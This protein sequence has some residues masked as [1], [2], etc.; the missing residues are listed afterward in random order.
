[1]SFSSTWRSEQRSHDTCM[2]PPCKL[3]RLLSGFYPFSRFDE[4]ME[5]KA[6][7]RIWDTGFIMFHLVSVCDGWAWMCWAV[8]AECAPCR[9]EA[10]GGHLPLPP[11]P[12]TVARPLALSPPALKAGQLLGR[13]GPASYVDQYY[14]TIRATFQTSLSFSERGGLVDHVQWDGPTLYTEPQIHSTSRA[15]VTCKTGVEHDK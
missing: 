5:P 9:V 14:A 15:Q 2:Q 11:A 1:M 10:K 4:L 8:L 13:S 7:H 12:P 3:S 6:T